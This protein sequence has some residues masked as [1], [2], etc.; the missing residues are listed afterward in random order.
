M[1]CPVGPYFGAG[2]KAQAIKVAD[3][4]TRAASGGVA[5]AKTAGNYAATLR[6]TAQAVKGG[7]SQ[8]LWLDADN[9]NI[10]EF[11]MMNVFF[12]LNGKILLTPSVNDETILP[13]ITRDSILKIAPDLGFEQIQVHVTIDD[14]ID[15]YKRGELTEIFGCGTAAN[16]SPVRLLNFKGKVIDVGTD[17]IG[18]AAKKFDEHLSGIQNGTIKDTRN[19]VNLIHV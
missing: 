4:H 5:T 9:K 14:I 13:G 2:G 1:L 17:T 12:V 19:W 16:I 7:Y 8:V 11:G 15:M 10:Q 6:T 3:K 18:P